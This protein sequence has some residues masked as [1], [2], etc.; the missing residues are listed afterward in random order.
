MKNLIL[1]LALTVSIAGAAVLGEPCIPDGDTQDV[2][3]TTNED[4]VP[5]SGEG[6]ES[7][8]GSDD[9]LGSATETSSGGNTT[10]SVP[11]T[12]NGGTLSGPNGVPQNGG[13]EGDCIEVYVKFKIRYKVK[14]CNGTPVTTGGDGPGDSSAE[15]CWEEWREKE[16][17]FS[18]P[19]EICPC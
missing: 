2:D 3:F 19:K 9:A 8:L 10:F 13:T 11:I 16:A 12:N 4:V 5:G 15:D 6:M 17:E 18:E 1:S 14:V 7:D